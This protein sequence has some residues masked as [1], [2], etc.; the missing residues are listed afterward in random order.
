[1]I[2]TLGR[3]LVTRLLDGTGV[4][5]DGGR[6]WDIQVNDG[7]FFRRALRGSLGIGESYV[8][9]DWDCRSLDELFRRVLGAGKSR[10][11]L[12]RLTRAFK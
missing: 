1:M 8:D 11:P 4:R 12:L 2:Q 6:P 3:R 9:G 7:R 5:I 10:S